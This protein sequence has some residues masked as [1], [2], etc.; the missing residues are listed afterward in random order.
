MSTN[1]EPKPMFE[2]GYHKLCD[3]DASVTKR[4]WSRTRSRR[5]RVA[6]SSPSAPQDPPSRR[7]DARYISRGTN[8]SWSGNLEREYQIRYLPRHLV[9]VQYYEVSR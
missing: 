5:C 2:Q 7:A 3:E 4:S 8:S 6:G 1:E 9:M